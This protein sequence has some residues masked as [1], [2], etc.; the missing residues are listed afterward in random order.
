[1]EKNEKIQYAI[2]GTD[3]KMIQEK[4]IIDDEE[5]YLVYWIEN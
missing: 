3:L 4:E 2:P 5:S 1:M